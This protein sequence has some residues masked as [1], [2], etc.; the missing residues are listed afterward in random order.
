SWGF[1]ARFPVDVHVAFNV[2]LGVL[3]MPFLNPLSTLIVKLLPI[4]ADA[5]DSPKY[6]TDAALITPQTALLAAQRETLRIGD[7]VERMLENSLQALRNDEEELVYYIRSQDDKVDA[8]QEATKKFIAKLNR[9][10]LSEKDLEFS[11]LIVNYSI[12]LEHVGDIIEKSLSRIAEKKS[13]KQIMFSL[14]GF[15]EIEI[16]FMRTIENLHLAQTVFMTRD[17]KLARQL[18]ESKEEIRR[19]ESDSSTA[20]F[21]RYQEKR[22]ETVLSSSLHLDILRD[23]KRINAHLTSVAYPILTEIG[24]LRES[25]LRAEEEPRE[26]ATPFVPPSPE[27]EPLPPP[28]PDPEPDLPPQDQD[29]EEEIKEG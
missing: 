9:T 18:V 20:H 27:P 6:L 14:E 15:N 12:N 17:P 8:L 26:T 29:A 28:L 11:D 22:F 16:M 21:K 23:L 24:V 13:E 10:Q 2:A 25:R 19:M 7:T 1:G 5:P 3:F 4:P